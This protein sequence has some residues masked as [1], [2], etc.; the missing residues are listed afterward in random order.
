[1]KTKIEIARKM[2]PLLGVPSASYVF[3]K[4]G[5]ILWHRTC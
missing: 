5:H 4:D 3:P 1:M 2:S